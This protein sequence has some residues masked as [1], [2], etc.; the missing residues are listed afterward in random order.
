MH[1]V[2]SLFSIEFVVVCL[3]GEGGKGQRDAVRIGERQKGESEEE[4]EVNEIMH[5]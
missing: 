4:R 2:N 3:G 5:L 1:T